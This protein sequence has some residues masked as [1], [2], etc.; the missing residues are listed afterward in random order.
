MRILIIADVH[1]R[2][3]IKNYRL[4]RSLNGLKKAFSTLD[5]DLIVFLGDLVHGPDYG[6][7]KGRYISDLKEVLDTTAGHPFAYV[8]GNHDDECAISKDEIL[9]LI[10]SYENSLT[11]GRNYV[12]NMKDETL[13]FIDSGSYYE[14]DGSFYDVVPEDTIAWAKE[15]IKGKK[16]IAFQHIIVPDIRTVVDKHKIGKGHIY[17]FKPGYEYTGSLRES[18]SPPNI[19]TGELKE[20]APYLKGIAFGHDHKNDFECLIEG[21]KIIQC[22][23]SGMNCYEFPRRPR[24]KIL[25]T[26]TMETELI[27]L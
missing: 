9:D 5:Y 12:L 27:R 10:R 22:P 6:D 11:D 15:Q 4:R 8:F 19:N 3:R 1:H 14:G 13:L 23:A 20:L 26:E 18:P 21:V 16:A 7:D 24:A 25:D 17:R 2:F